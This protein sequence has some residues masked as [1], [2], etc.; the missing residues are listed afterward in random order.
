MTSI[1][2]PAIEIAPPAQTNK[3]PRNG[4]NS[5]DVSILGSQGDP[6]FLHLI[7][8]GAECKSNCFRVVHPNLGNAMP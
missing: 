1:A 5:I 6:L 4:F 7:F 2:P 8:P 3:A